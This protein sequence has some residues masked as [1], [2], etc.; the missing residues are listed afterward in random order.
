MVY[1]EGTL[2]TEVGD[3]VHQMMSPHVHK[4]VN[5][6]KEVRTKDGLL[7]IGNEENPQKETTKTKSA[8][9]IAVCNNELGCCLLLL[10]QVLS[11]VLAIL[12]QGRMTL[13]SDPVSTRKRIPVCVS[14]TSNRQLRQHLHEAVF[15]EKLFF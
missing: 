11:Y 14:C 7:C 3:C 15:T 12:L 2:N 10:G 1:S 8:R 5:V 6:T 13:T 9:V 4:E